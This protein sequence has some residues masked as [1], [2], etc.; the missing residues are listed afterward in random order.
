[1][2]HS[3]DPFLLIIFGLIISIK[4]CEFTLKMLGT[5]CETVNFSSNMK[6]FSFKSSHRAPV[7][8]KRSGTAMADSLGWNTSS[9]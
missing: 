1:M 5:S 3:S 6:L 4:N 9:L 8:Y 7:V 2:A